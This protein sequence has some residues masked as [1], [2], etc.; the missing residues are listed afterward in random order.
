MK[1]ELLALCVHE[2]DGPL[3]QDGEAGG[4]G[5]PA[6]CVQDSEA[7]ATWEGQQACLSVRLSGLTPEGEAG[8]AAL[9]PPTFDCWAFERI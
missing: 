4:M 5:A 8:C 6:T 3:G 2:G 7:K 9:H 1:T